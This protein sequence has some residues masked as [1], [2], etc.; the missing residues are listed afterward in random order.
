M[1]ENHK[2]D[3][4]SKWERQ[5][6]T[7]QSGTIWDEFVDTVTCGSGNTYDEQDTMLTIQ[8]YRSTSAHNLPWEVQFAYTCLFMLPL[9]VSAWEGGGLLRRLGIY[10]FIATVTITSMWYCCFQLV[11]NFNFFRRDQDAN[12]NPWRADLEHMELR[13]LVRLEDGSL[14][15]VPEASCVGDQIWL[16]KGG[17]MPLTLR[18]KGND[19]E[20][21]G[22]C[23]SATAL[24]TTRR[25]RNL[26]R[27]WIKVV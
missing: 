24:K 8:R 14:A 2:L 18:P 3:T 12:D 20:M 15:L 9:A 10:W 19:F 13:R 6:R 22:E 27:H 21:V 25:S 26:H 5:F 17:I 23:Y 11:P 7:P 16:C 4:L 1:A